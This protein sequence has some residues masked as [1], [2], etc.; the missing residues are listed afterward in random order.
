MKFNLLIFILLALLVSSLF[1]TANQAPVTIIGTPRDNLV[2]PSLDVTFSWVY[3][4]AESDK[5]QNYVFQ[6]SFDDPTFT[7]APTFYGDGERSLSLRLPRE[8]RYFWRVASSDVFNF[9]EYSNPQIFYVTVQKQTCFDGTSYYS[10]S[11]NKPFFCN[12][13]TLVS[14]CQVCGCPV[15]SV[16]EKNGQCS[17]STCS[18]G[19]RLGACSRNKPVLCLNGELQEVCSI[20][21][22]PQGLTC[23]SQGQCIF[24]LEPE[25][26][27]EEPLKEVEEK[28]SLFSYLWGL[29]LSLF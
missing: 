7:Q 20:C 1:A 11:Q 22:C 21:G 27:I 2:V 25:N 29:I 28:T 12:A 15:N 13:Q 19:T 24:P 6:Y 9:G 3:K 5:Q 10:C 16:C 18:D 14:N 23:G 17:L 26:I 4:D 8:G